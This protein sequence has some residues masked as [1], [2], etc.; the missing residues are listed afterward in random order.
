MSRNIYDFPFST[1]PGKLEPQYNSS[2]MHASTEPFGNHS[3]P[4]T[5]FSLRATLLIGFAYRYVSKSVLLLDLQR[6]LRRGVLLTCHERNLY[7]SNQN[8]H[9][10]MFWRKRGIECIHHLIRKQNPSMVEKVNIWWACSIH[11]RGHN[12]V[13]LSIKFWSLRCFISLFVEFTCI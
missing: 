6:N 3:D 7:E 13:S 9:C 1:H 8:V 11:L 4:I 10:T 5:T 2:S 12:W